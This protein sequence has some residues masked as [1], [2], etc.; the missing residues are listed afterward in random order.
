VSIKP[1]RR[2]KGCRI[3]GR[4]RIFYGTHNPLCNDVPRNEERS[5]VRARRRCR[6]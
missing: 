1:R 4:N 2:Q 6:P 5:A 3:G